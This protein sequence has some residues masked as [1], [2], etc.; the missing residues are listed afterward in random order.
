MANSA[1]RKY[2]GIVLALA[3]YGMYSFHYATMKWLGAHHSLWQL[4]FIR[5]VVMVGITLAVSKRGT[6]AATMASPYKGPTLVRGILQFLS[7]ACF[8]IAAQKM[9]LSEVTTLY[10]TAPLIIV[11]LSMFLLRESI[12]GFRWIALI[13]GVA[14]TIIAARPGGDVSVFPALVALASGLF[15]ALTVVFTRKSGARER[16]SVQLL[17]NGLVFTVLSG[18]LMTWSTPATLTEW[19]WMIGQGAQVYLALYFFFEACRY[20]PASLVGPL[21]YSSVVWSC[22][23]GYMMFSNIPTPQVLL[24]AVLVSAS[25]IVLAGSARPRQKQRVA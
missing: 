19:M 9:S 5:S 2:L 24:G 14:G 18:I 12:H 3:S 11:V 7:M 8:F 6:V 15:W 25:G 22:L 1:D 21:E 17:L 23:F 20:A 13:V 4:V 16:S 10:T